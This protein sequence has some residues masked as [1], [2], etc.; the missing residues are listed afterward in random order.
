MSYSSQP[1]PE[2]AKLAV[3]RALKK[4]PVQ[5]VGGVLLFLTNGYARA[6]EAA[7]KAAA[8]ASSSTQITGC[9]SA[10]ILTEEEWLLDAEGAAAMIFG[11][12]PVL[13]P[14]RLA[15]RATTLLNLSC[16]PFARI[17]IDQASKPMIGAVTS[18]DYGQGPYS[19]WQS[20]RPVDDGYLLA[21]FDADL[22]SGIAVGQGI[23]QL[24]GVMK[25]TGTEGSHLVSI[26]GKPALE[27]LLDSIPAN[28]RGLS[29]KQPHHI[30][31]AISETSSRTSIER[32]FFK[33]RHVVTTDSDKGR[34]GLTGEVHNDYHI[35]WAIRDEAAAQQAHE[36]ALKTAAS[37]L[38]REPDFALVFPSISRG[39]GFYGGRDRDIELLQARFP[40]LPL[41][42]FYGNGE[43]APGMQSPGLLH[44]YSTVTGLF[45]CA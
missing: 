40:D 14:Y 21:G 16:P 10:G 8:R 19:V 25:I 35:F 28:L 43:I 20:G 33:L 36:S 11:G 22:R 2:H 26:D 44:Q 32:G 6:P 12:K 23:R 18:D 34:V 17:S 1:R 9:C 4:I 5:G 37:A 7:L 30:L 41:I 27:G 38:G 29:M 42:G 31:C 45:A 15:P 39:P 13:Q 3:E 24:S